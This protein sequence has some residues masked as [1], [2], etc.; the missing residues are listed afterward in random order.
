MGNANE[1]FD[2]SYLKSI[3]Q[4][5]ENFIIEMVKTFNEQAPLYIRNVTKFQGENNLIGISK[6]AH[7]LV[8]GVG[9]MGMKPLEADLMKLEEYTKNNYNLD[10]VEGLIKTS[11]EKI[12]RIMDGFNKEYKLS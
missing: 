3:S 9:F 1:D 8:P 11:I 10:Q 4:G 2:L 5:D 6:E 12:N 7:K